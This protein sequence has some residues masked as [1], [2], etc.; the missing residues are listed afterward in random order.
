MREVVLKKYTTK[1]L[2]SKK[3]ALGID[4]EAL[5]EAFNDMF[6]INNLSI[7]G[8][9]IMYDEVSL[10]RTLVMLFDNIAKH[11]SDKVKLSKEPFIILKENIKTIDNII[12]NYKTK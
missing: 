10:A 4:L 5:E 3:E 9:N 8:T 12:E 2:F 6:V 7:D 1:L 11:Y